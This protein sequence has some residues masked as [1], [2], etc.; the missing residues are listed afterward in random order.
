MSLIDQVI[1]RQ[2][3]DSRGNPTVEVDVIL[4]D[5]VM[6]RASVPSGA[7]TGEHEAV[8]LRDGDKSLFMGKSVVKAVDNVNSVIADELKGCPALMQTDLDDLL[9]DLGGTSNKGS[10]GASEITGVSLATATAGANSLGVPLWRYLGGVNAK[11]MP[12]QM[13]KRIGR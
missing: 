11:L 10:L 2:I 3:I 13:M 7:S 8:E 4:N 5:G 1:G 6:G 12:V 9:I